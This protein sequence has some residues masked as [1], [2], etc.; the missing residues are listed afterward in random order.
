MKYVPFWHSFINM[1]CVFC[2]ILFWGIVICIETIWRFSFV[3]DNL[4]E[5]QHTA[6]T[7][8]HHGQPTVKLCCCWFD[9]QGAGHQFVS[10]PDTY[11]LFPCQY[12][13]TNISLHNSP[14]CYMHFCVLVQV[15]GSI[16]FPPGTV[17]VLFGILRPRPIC[18]HRV[19]FTE[20]LSIFS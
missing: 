5:I 18:C 14:L 3:L 19:I 4:L 16:H 15:A 10:S 8:G 2:E 6:W 20:P 11:L 12:R 13:A 1:L 7:D 17:K 9:L